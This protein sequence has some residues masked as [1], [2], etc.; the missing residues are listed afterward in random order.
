MRGDSITARR[1]VVDHVRRYKTLTSVPISTGW[2]MY[3]SSAR[4]KYIQ[5]KE[6][7]RKKR[8]VEAV[9][10]KRKRAEEIVEEMKA[11]KAR[12]QKDIQWPSCL[13]ETLII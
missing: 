5:D 1:Q 12:I 8:E 9:G 6:E 2:I 13:H 3:C 11:K 7:Q 4:R 10:R